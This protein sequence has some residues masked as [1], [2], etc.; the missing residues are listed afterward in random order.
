MG[1]WVVP[2]HEEGG[3]ILMSGIIP[4]GVSGL[5]DAKKPGLGAVPLAR[6]SFTATSAGIATFSLGDTSLLRHDGRGTALAH[7][8]AGASIVVDDGPPSRRRSGRFR[9]HRAS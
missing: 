8:D 3:K 4:G 5:Y 1:L 6:L 7:E 9:R 2:P